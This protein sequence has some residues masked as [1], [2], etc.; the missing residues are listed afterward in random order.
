MFFVGEPKIIARR[1]VEVT[2]ASMMRGIEVVK[3]GATLGD[4]GHAIQSFAATQPFSV[5]P[6]FCR[7]G[8]GP[9]FHAAP[10]VLHYVRPGTGLKLSQDI[11]ISLNP[12]ITSDPQQ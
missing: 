2:Y 9:L 4:I 5:V 11:L 12:M 3:P 6:D 8:L 7:H 10:T 1:L